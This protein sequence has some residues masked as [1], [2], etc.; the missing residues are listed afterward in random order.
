VAVVEQLQL[1]DDVDALIWGYEKSGI[2]SSHSCYAIISYRGVTPIYIPAIWNILVPPKIQLFLWLLSHNKIATVDNLN[3]R[4]FNKHKQCCFCCEGESICH[5]F[6]DSIIAK[7][8]WCFVSE[9]L[10]YEIE[11]DYLSVASKWIHK[12]KYFNVNI[13]STAVLRSIWLTRNDF[14]FNKQAWVDVKC[15]LRRS[16][17]LSMEWKSIYMATQMEEMMS[18]SSFLE[19]LIKNL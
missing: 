14:V 6:F 15:I 3:T 17:K 5:L 11:G 1:N 8:M 13:I 19:K 16:L 12:D 7:V 4:G 10:G 2:Y 18:W 9:F